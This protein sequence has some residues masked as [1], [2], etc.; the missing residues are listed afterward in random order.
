MVHAQGLL[1]VETDQQR[2]C[3]ILDLFTE[4]D[5]L[6]RPEVPILMDPLQISSLIVFHYPFV[7]FQFQWY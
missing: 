6:L 5:R 3:T 2:R 7:Q 4:I 1:S